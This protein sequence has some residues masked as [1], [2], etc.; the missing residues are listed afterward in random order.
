[1]CDFLQ[2]HDVLKNFKLVL[3]SGL[4]LGATDKWFI[5]SGALIHLVFKLRLGALIPRS[6]GRSVGL[7]V[8]RSVL[9]KLQKNYKTLQNITK[10]YKTLQ[11]TT[12]HY[13][14][15]QNVT[16]HYKTLK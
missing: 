10:R 4:S 13:K 2:I 9:Q 5:S 12:K 8:G 3:W 6:V 7:S 14:T 11:N 16:K 15:L 1:M